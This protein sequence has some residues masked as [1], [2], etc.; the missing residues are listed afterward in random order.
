MMGACP[1]WYLL[2]RAARYLHIAPWEF[3]RQWAGWMHR[4][5][6]AEAA[7]NGAKNV[8]VEET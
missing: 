6:A 3:E 8:T 4:A 5:L 2:V 7:E 1:D